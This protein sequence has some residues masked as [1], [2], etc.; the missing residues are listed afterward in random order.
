MQFTNTKLIKI[1]KISYA[2][3]AMLLHTK[4]HFISVKN[5]HLIMSKVYLDNNLFYK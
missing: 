4:L 2:I 3:I 1:L 5:M